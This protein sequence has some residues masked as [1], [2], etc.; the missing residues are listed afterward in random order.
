[1]ISKTG[2]RYWSTGITVTWLPRAHTIDGEPFPGWNASLEFF[3]DG[4]MDD[5]VEQGEASTQGTLGT[6]Y[7]VR[8][9]KTVSGLTLAV[10]NLITDAERLGIEFRWAEGKLP[11]LYYKGDGEDSNYAPPEGWRETLRA[12]A[13]R[14]GWSTYATA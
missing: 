8:D 13:E 10:D 9:S 1:M 7:Y 12:E 3:D 11:V 2:G 4:F 14:L 5:R 6:R